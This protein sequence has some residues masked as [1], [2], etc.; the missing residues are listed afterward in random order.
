MMIKKGD[1]VTLQYR[2][3]IGTISRG[4]HNNL[5]SFEKL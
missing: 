1:A 2:F 4:I 3:Y 5:S